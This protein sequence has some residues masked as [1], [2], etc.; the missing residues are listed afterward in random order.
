MVNEEKEKP[1]MNALASIMMAQAL[2]HMPTRTPSEKRKGS[3]ASKDH[4]KKRKAEK[5]RRK[6]NRRRKK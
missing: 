1:S 4:R 3:T 6:K 2:A 5:K